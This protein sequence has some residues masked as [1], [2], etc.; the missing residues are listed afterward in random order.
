MAS[1]SLVGRAK[2]PINGLNMEYRHF[3]LPEYISWYDLHFQMPSN[4]LQVLF[5][6]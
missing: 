4:K 3:F 6:G 2:A 5:I 1:G